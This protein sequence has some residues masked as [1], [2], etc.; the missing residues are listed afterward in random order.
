MGNVPVTRPFFYTGQ[1]RK[2]QTYIHNRKRISNTQSKDRARLNRRPLRAVESAIG[3]RKYQ[4]VIAGLMI[5][6]EFTY[7][8]ELLNTTHVRRQVDV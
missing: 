8:L 7:S 5:N 2:L 3:L 1:R 6:L 4:Q